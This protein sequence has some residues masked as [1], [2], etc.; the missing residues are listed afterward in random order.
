LSRPEKLKP[1]VP[2]LDLN[3]AL[4]SDPRL[5]NDIKMNQNI[6]PSNETVTKR[7]KRT[8]GGGGSVQ[9]LSSSLRRDD[10]IN[11]EDGKCD[12]N[13]CLMENNHSPYSYEKT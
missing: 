9:Q 10:D 5:V 11:D 3:L 6:E 2:N 7:L 12:D 4:T 1:D 13:P 8:I